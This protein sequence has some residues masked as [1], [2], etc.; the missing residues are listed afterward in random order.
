MPVA[1]AARIVVVDNEPDHLDG[2]MNALQQLDLSCRPL[3]YPQDLDGAR[4]SPH[5]RVLF[6]DLN[7][8]EGDMSPD[9]T[10]CYSAIG[11]LIQHTVQPRG[12]YIMVLW[13]QHDGHAT[14]L[15]TYLGDNLP[16][17][18]CPLT[19]APLAKEK[20]LLEGTVID[21]QALVEAIDEVVATEPRVAAL[22]SWEA[23]VMNAAGHTVSEIGRLARLVND[24]DLAGG[25]AVLLAKLAQASVGRVNVD[26]DRFGAVNR[27]LVPVLADRVGTS[28]TQ[29]KDDTASEEAWHAAFDEKDVE[30]KLTDR[31]AAALNCASLIAPGEKQ[32][33]VARGAV[34]LLS[35]LA[36]GEQYWNNFGL[37]D[38][39]TVEKQF[40][41]TGYN[42]PK[43]EMCKRVL[44]Q[45]Q[46]ACDHAQGQP[47]PLPFY[48]GL[49][50][51]TSRIRKGRKPPM[52]CWTSPTF[53][54]SGDDEIRVLHVNARF[55]IFLPRDIVRP[56]IPVYRLREQLI[57]ELIYHIHSYG[58][59]PG[60]ISFR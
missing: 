9:P 41:C 19:V 23:H 10:T 2:L 42:D 29:R 57:N 4:P 16:V 52:A 35:D 48:L 34:V 46:A 6:T 25:I 32:V 28:A 37:S 14:E 51:P 36:S 15:L 22:L 17:D 7:L 1:P 45:A 58:S 5:V 40:G 24:S 53:T 21:A 13:T 27:A 11:G 50:L 43:K 26:R 20:Y 8:V 44:V 33:G 31:I 18:L 12:P 30:T 38:T 54:D 59:R 47:G 39:A 49:E 56:I 3:Y 55:G 60:V